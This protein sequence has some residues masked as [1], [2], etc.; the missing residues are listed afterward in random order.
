MVE[1]YCMHCRKKVHMEDTKNV[2]TANGKSAVR[3]KCP[4][5]H[6][7][8]FK[9]VKSEGKGKKSGGCPCNIKG[10]RERRSK[11]SKKSGGRQKRSR[12]SSRSRK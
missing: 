8:M 10:S 6:G 5:C 2:K 7:N 3:G 12:R 9:F 4:H 11:R 1:G